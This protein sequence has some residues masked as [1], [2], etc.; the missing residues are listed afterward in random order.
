[1]TDKQYEQALIDL[2]DD[3]ENDRITMQ[4]YRRYLRELDEE[5]EDSNR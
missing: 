4:E 3:L 2:E 5:Y 1:M